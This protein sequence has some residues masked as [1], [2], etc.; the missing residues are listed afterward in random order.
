[1]KKTSVYLGDREI[2][3]LAW[4]AEREG[5]SQA[6]IIRRA[7]HAYVPQRGGDR[8]FAGI[9]SAEG[10]GGSVAD[11]PQKELLRGFGEDALGE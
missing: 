10:P 3:R 9:A 7:L 8:N 6:T 2:E 1:M 11:I 4:L 5:T